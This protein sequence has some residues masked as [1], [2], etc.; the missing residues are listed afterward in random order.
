M[1][2]Y[3]LRYFTTP[4][5]LFSGFLLTACG[6]G[7]GGGSSSG[8]GTTTGQFSLSTSSLNFIAATPAVTA[9]SQSITGTVSGSLSGTLYILVSVSGNA[10]ASVSNFTVNPTTS[11]GMAYVSPANARVLGEGTHTATITVRACLNDSTCATG[12]LSGSPK[13][14]NVT[15][16]V[17]SSVTQETVMPHVVKSGTSGEVVIRGH[18]FITD[19]INN[20]KFNSTDAS[21]INVISETEIHATYPALTAGNYTLQLSNASGPAAFSGNLVAIDPPAFTAST[22]AYSTASPHVLKLVYDAERQAL[23]LAVSYF[24]GINFNTASRQTNEILRYQFSNGSLVSMS[25]ATVPLLQGMDL[26]PDGS[27]LIVIADRKV[28][29]LD[30]S[31]LAELASTDMD[32]LVSSSQYLKDV[33][34]MNDGN[35]LITSGYAGSGNTPVYI[36][37]ISQASLSATTLSFPYNG[38]LAGSANGSY[39]TIIQGIISPAQP[40]SDY[41]AST[42][43]LAQT[44]INANQVQCTNSYMDGCV[45]PAVAPTGSVFA[46]IDYSWTVSIYNRAYTLLGKLPVASKTVAFN[47][48][49]TSIYALDG[50]TL[51]KY[52]LTAATDTNN[53]FPEVGTGTA[54]SSPGSDPVRMI[55]SADGGTLLMAGKGQIVIQPAP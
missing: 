10:V 8:G 26:S 54:I 51:R 23:L 19:N 29:Q 25:S 55:L 22:V 21:S 41:T 50:N 9:S 31:T 43:V 4:I 53:N 42:G 35:A 15:Y 20:V 28:L 30:P 32:A 27:R 52:D 34:V 13:T 17:G 38:S 12:E 46:I 45:Y 14:I 18:N 11:S 49:G 1:L 16:Q 5:L 40:V 37:P 48:D 33:T 44:S 6:G 47:S 39:A 3:V 24:N 7:G 36:Y 2:P